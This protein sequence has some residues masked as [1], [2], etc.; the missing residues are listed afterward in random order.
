MIV[1]MV[2]VLAVAL[3]CLSFYYTRTVGTCR[4]VLSIARE[5]TNVL[6]DGN[7]DDLAKENAIKKSAVNMVKQCF[8]LFFKLFIVLGA[9]VL[10][11]WLADVL[12]LAALDDTSRFALRWDVL[13]ITTIAVV[14]PVVMLRKKA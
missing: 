5:S 7:L 11:L 9:T 1:A 3:F 10:P 2:Y 12:Q 6:T 4:Q 13:L 8:V 14:V